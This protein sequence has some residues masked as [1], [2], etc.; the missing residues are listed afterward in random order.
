[1]KKLPHM[2]MLSGSG[3]N[4]GKTTLS[5]QLITQLKKEGNVV[6][7]IKTSSH[8][9]P[10]DADELIILEGDGFAIVEE[11]RTNK[12]DS[13]LMLQAGAAKAYYIQA[14]A[15]KMEFAFQHVLNLIPQNAVII[16]ESGGA[17]AFIEPSLFLY[18][19]GNGQHKNADFKHLADLTLNFNGNGWDNFSPAMVTFDG[20]QFTLQ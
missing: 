7:S 4:V 9:H 15:G 10:L 5:T 20:K 16:C 18:L 2:L 19:T 8:L 1:M 3:K 6:Y 12:K 14:I 11:K 17:R 13:S